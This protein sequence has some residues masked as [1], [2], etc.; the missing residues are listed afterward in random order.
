[1]IVLL[2]LRCTDS[3][4]IRMTSLQ[5]KRKAEETMR[6]GGGPMIPIGAGF[7]YPPFAFSCLSL[8]FGS[9]SSSDSFGGAASSLSIHYIEWHCIHILGICGVGA[10]NGKAR[11]GKAKQQQ[12]QQQKHQ[13]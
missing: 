3:G 6:Q 7:G 12:Q 11:Q 4:D 2:L 8:M 5:R 1:M 13:V 10:A 9:S